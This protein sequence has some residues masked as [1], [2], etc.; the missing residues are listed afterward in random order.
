MDNEY[1]LVDNLPRNIA[2]PDLEKISRLVEW[3][4]KEKQPILACILHEKKRVSVGDMLYFRDELTEAGFKL[5]KD[6]SIKKLNGS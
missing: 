5:W 1:L 2:H 4:L 3:C 6:F